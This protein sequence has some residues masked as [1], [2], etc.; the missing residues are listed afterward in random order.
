MMSKL[1]ELIAQ[2]RAAPDSDAPR[3]AWANE[4]GGERGELV[5]L[6]CRLATG[7]VTN[8]DEWRRL[9][10]RER[11]LLAASGVAWS[12]LAGEYPSSCM[13]RRGSVESVG[14][15]CSYDIRL[16]GILA[17]VPLARSV[18]NDLVDHDD[19]DFAKLVANPRCSDLAALHV[20][21]CRRACYESRP[22]SQSPQYGPGGSQLSE[23]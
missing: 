7:A 17:R 8:R 10:A 15:V 20:G 4:V 14:I 22:A 5:I 3:L 6:Q 18:E 12:G 2:C 19:Y 21:H 11:E 1:D 13:F 9:R 16:D 23:F